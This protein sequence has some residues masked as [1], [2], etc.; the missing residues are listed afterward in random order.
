MGMQS[1]ARPVELAP[2]PWP[3]V[4]SGDPLG[5]SARILAVNL[6]AALGD[7]SVHSA[8]GDAGISHV[9]LLNVLAG[10]AWPDLA[11]VARLELSLGVPI[12]PKSR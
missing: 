5:E 6:R 3:D 4:T 10:R 11:T 1:R 12:Y 8:A 7:R 2:A 9:T